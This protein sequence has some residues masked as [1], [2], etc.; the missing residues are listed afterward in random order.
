M[1]P[2][3]IYI[4]CRSDLSPTSASI[5]C[6]LGFTIARSYVEP[7]FRGF[8][9]LK[10]FTV[11]KMQYLRKKYVNQMFRGITLF[12]CGGVVSENLR[13][14]SSLV[15][16]RRPCF[17]F[18]MAKKTENNMPSSWGIANAVQKWE[19]WSLSLVVFLFCVFLWLCLLGQ[20]GRNPI[21]ICFSK[22][23]TF[24]WLLWMWSP[25]TTLINR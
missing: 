21:P 14:K 6:V 1:E 13:G 17:Y 8:I 4:S 15:L 3:L 23:C 24:V 22:D 5:F 20:G 16:L 10:Y 11:Q 25:V 12:V 7:Y 19:K 2:L 9:L 18:P